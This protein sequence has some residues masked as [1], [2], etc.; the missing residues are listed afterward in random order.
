MN[1][2][3]PSQPPV[4]EGDVMPDLDPDTSLPQVLGGAFDAFEEIRQLARS[5]E[6]R[7]PDLFAAFM[8][9]AVAAANGRDAVLTAATIPA[10]GP[11]AAGPARP[12][13]GADVREVADSI[14]ASAAVLAARLDHAAGLAVT[15]QDRRA[16]HDGAAAARQIHQLLVSADDAHAR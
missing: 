2:R 12:A 10:P 11:G 14:A 9:A 7:S 4:M 5:C 13:P 1:S 6:D 15:S 8:S 3:Y 16:C